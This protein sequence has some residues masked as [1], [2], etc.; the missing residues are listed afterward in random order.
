MMIN[1]V[2]GERNAASVAARRTFVFLNLH[3][4]PDRSFKRRV[5][6]DLAALSW[7][8]ATPSRRLQIPNEPYWVR[9]ISAHGNGQRKLSKRSKTRNC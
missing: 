8:R 2:G 7:S 9:F 4:A 1:K 3:D 5:G 6:A